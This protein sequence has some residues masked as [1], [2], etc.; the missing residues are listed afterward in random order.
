V[1]ALALVVPAFVIVR[2]RRRVRRI[3]AEFS[4]R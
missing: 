4:R 3:E 2:N 1:A